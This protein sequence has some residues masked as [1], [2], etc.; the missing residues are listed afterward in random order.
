M[1][2]GSP[3]KR[4]RASSLSAPAAAASSD[5]PLTKSQKARLRKKKR[6]EESNSTAGWERSYS[7]YIDQGRK[8]FLKWQSLVKDGKQEEAAVSCRSYNESFGLAYKRYQQICEIKK[9]PQLPAGSFIQTCKVNP[10][11]ISFNK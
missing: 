8:E 6:D 1:V 11:L 2:P 5:V 10:S 9:I 4:P 3:A 7:N